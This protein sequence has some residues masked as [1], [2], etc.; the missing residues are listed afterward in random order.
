MP[1]FLLNPGF[2]WAP[3]LFTASGFFP[4]L[5]AP[6]NFPAVSPVFI[7]CSAFF[8]WSLISATCFH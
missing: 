4:S 8:G 2:F 6:S 1:L 7:A 3:G 5:T